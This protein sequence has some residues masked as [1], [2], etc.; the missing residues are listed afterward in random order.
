MKL[1][2]QIIKD[3]CLNALKKIDAKSVDLIY[4]D[5]PFY[6]QR[7]HQQKTR[8]NSKEYSF[9]DVW[10]DLEEYIHYIEVRVRECSRI[11][12]DT[13]SIFLH[14]DKKASHHLRVMLD[15]VFGEDNFKSD[16]VWTYKRWSNAKEGLLNSHQN[17]FFY[18]KTSNFKFNKIFT[19]YSPTTN[20][21]Q[22]L[23]ARERDVNN[24]SVYKRNAEGQVVLGKEKQGVPLSDVWDIPFLNP[25]AEERVGYPTQKPI[26]L[27]ERI[28]SL[29]TDV[30][31]VVLDPFCGSGTTLVAASLL[32]RKYIGFD[33][34]KDA[35]ALAKKRIKN[36]IKTTSHLMEK[37]K[38]AYM[39][40][41]EMVK[42]ILL[43]IDATVVQ[44]NK[45]IDGFL[46]KYYKGKP[47]AV[48]VQRK[49]QP[50]V[51]AVSLLKNAGNKK[52]SIKKILIRTNNP[53]TLLSKISDEI[54]SDDIIII[55]YIGYKINSLFSKEISV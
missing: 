19:D 34:S 48:Y 20:I 51:D 53:D 54:N 36:P 49:D 25:K 13:G 8:D 39:N 28:I 14:C 38:E 30:G 9:E 2:N 17:I 7:K 41:D 42:T 37:G 15:R 18:S 5:P 12:K 4:L 52:G 50:L 43:Q 11:L 23:Q 40:K 44:R 10:N 26:I 47:V 3:D 32:G 35:V 27:L 29:T 45:G 1:I 22:I 21:D 33:S 31:D 6:T 16:I 55:D 46:K 24:K